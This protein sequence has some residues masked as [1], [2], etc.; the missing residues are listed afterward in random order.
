MKK[1]KRVFQRITKQRKSKGKVRFKAFEKK[2]S[3]ANFVEIAREKSRDYSQMKHMK[4]ELEIAFPSYAEGKVRESHAKMI[5]SSLTN[6]IVL[7]V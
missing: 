6:I 4:N 5:H 1:H 3:G 2:N 7:S